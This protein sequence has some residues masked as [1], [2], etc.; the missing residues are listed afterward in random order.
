MV[1]KIKVLIVDDSMFFSELLKKGI[2]SDPKLEVIAMASDPYE[3]REKILKYN[4]DVMTLDVNMPK[5]NGIEFLKKLM[6]Q[7]PMKVVVVSSVNNIILDALRAGAVEFV[8]KPSEPNKNS[9]IN[10]FRELNEK[11]HIAS[12]SKVKIPKPEIIKKSIIPF[13]STQ[14]IKYRKMVIA[15]GASTGGTEAIYEVIKDLPKYMPPIVIVQHMPP[16]FSKLFA[17]RLNNLCD[18]EIKEAKSGDK[19]EVGR[20]LIAPGGKQMKVKESS[21]GYYVSCIDEDSVWGHCPS[22]SVLFDSVAK[23]YKKNAFGIILTGM[24]KDGSDGMLNMRNNG[25]YNLGQNEE[26]SV[27]YGM[28]KVAFQLGGVNEQIKLNKISERLLEIVNK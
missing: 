16:E 22:V 25:A 28:P 7:K 12:I 26:S 19:L 5:M 24:G 4:P 21:S 6:P 8:G 9:I 17:D 15:I 3:A 13:N 18:L 27:V 14:I 2:N 11:I 23:V 20:V 1:N 10:F